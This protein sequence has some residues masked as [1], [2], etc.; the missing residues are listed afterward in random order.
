MRDKCV[1]NQSGNALF[2]MCLAVPLTGCFL[3]IVFNTVLW[4]TLLLPLVVFM[5]GGIFLIAIAVFVVS[6]IIGG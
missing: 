3:A 5:E 6:W 4:L 1:E 2:F